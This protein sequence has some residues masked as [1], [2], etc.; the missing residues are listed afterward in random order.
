MPADSSVLIIDDEAFLR[1]T[2]GIILQRAGYTVTTASGAQEALQVLLKDHFDLVF[3]DLKMPGKD[4]L[5]LLPEIRLLDPNLPVLILTANASLDTAIQ[6]MRMGAVGYLM[7]PIDPEQIIN[8]IE[9]T[10]KEHRRTRQSRD[11]SRKETTD[12]IQGLLG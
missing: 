9:E 3:L 11:P 7:K 1:T 4:G 2:L 6:S 12:E 10:L 8:R 5:E